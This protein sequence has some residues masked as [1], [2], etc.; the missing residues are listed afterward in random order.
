MVT[1]TTVDN[2]NIYNIDNGQISIEILSLGATINR[3][4][5]ADKCGNPT[6]VA[7]G[8]SSIQ[9]LKSG[10]GYIGATIGRCC[11][12]IDKGRFLLEG[13]QYQVTLNDG[14]NSLH[15][16]TVGFDKHNWTCLQQGDNYITLSTDSKAGD[17]GYPSSLHIEVT[18]SAIESSLVIEYRAT[19]DGVTVCNP[20]NHVYFNLNGE[21]NGDILDNML[22]LYADSYLP[23]DDTLIPTGQICSVDGTPFDFRQPK[24]IGADISVDNNQL[25][26]AGGYDHNYCVVGQHVATA[27]SPNSGIVMDVYSDRCGVQFYSGNFLDGV[28]GKSLYNKRA[29][30][31]LETQCYPDSINNQLGDSVILRQDKEL[32]TKTKY[33]FSNN[34]DDNR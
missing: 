27:S 33:V 7:L 1:I 17:Q 4:V 2:Y 29:G 3:I 20:T 5:V 9:Q 19:T 26:I 30:F 11:N 32:Y 6:D 23:I 14:D 16:G 8:Y 28:V 25:A 15:G 18:F 13:C 10:D 12:R 21:G 34:Q 31:C 24:S 22:T